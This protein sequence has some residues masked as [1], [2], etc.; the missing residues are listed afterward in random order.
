MPDIRGEL[1][2]GAQFTFAGV[3]PVAFRE[4]E[5]EHPRPPD[6]ARHDPALPIA[7][8]A[9]FPDI[10]AGL[11]A[12]AARQFLRSTAEFGIDDA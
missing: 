9:L 11:D 10:A 6:L 12:L 8:Q 1:F 5:D 2:E 7:V 3:A 4:Q